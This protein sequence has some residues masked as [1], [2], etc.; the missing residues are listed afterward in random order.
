MQLSAGQITTFLLSISI[1]LFLAKILGELFTKLKQPA[2]VGEIIA[3]ILLGPT[4]FG[5]ISPESFQWLFPQHGEIKIALDS[6]T[7][8][9]VIL[10]LLISGLDVDLSI[11][12]SQGKK[13][14]STSFMGLVAPFILGFGVSY[15]FPQLMGIGEDG[16]KFVFALFM[17]TALSISALPVIAKTLMDLNIFK[18]RLGFIIIA[19]AMLNDLF[20]WLIFSIILGLIGGNTHGFTFEQTL[21]FTITFV[22]FVLSIG[23]KIINRIIPWIQTKISFPGGILNFIL[24]M[25]FLGAAFT[26]FI[27]IHAIFGAFIVGI[28]IGDSVHLKENTRQ[29]IHQFVSNIF[30][31]LFFVSIGL[32]VNFIANFD[33][34]IVVTILILAFAGKV[35][36]CGFGAYWSGLNKNESLVVGFGMNSRGAMEIILGILALQAG[37]IHEEVFVGL[38]I[39]ALFTSISSAPLMS[40]FLKEKDK[41]KFKYLVKEEFVIISN[42]SEK[43]K[44]ISQLVDIASEEL[45]IKKEIIFKEVMTREN[46]LPTGIANYLAVPHAKIKIKEPF[47][48]IAINKKG[49]N[50]EAG[51]GLPSKI[52]VLL[53]TP[54]NNN[55][56]QLQ[57]LAEIASKFKEKDKVVKLVSC[58]EKSEFCEAMREMA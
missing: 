14:I 4:V 8:V 21:F 30:A 37:L 36:G 19:A 24:I 40:Y 31:P 32:R 17:G 7:T 53:L 28:A 11:V 15:L 26:E 52:I 35:V 51:D 10:L 25:G 6:F 44:V 3:G 50:F 47:M 22:L 9:A 13:A 2:I 27:G 1:M 54:E 48:C 5:M 46:S 34:V 41:T 57:L 42:E 29:I 16:S 49:I 18:T 56:L 43:E 58:E 45:K 39:M 12:L 55:E 23:K 33:I 38:V 20:G